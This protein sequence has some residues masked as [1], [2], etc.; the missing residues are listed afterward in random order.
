MHTTPAAP[1]VQ[2]KSGADLA[3]IAV[4]ATS[5]GI[6]NDSHSGRLGQVL[7]LQ[8]A[9]AIHGRIPHTNNPARQ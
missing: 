7:T 4:A 1:S 9:T 6:R 3:T 8:S 2:L 5:E